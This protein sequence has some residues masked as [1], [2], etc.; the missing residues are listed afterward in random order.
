VKICLIGTFSGNLDEGYRNVAFNLSKHLS[1][2]HNI[3]N[4]DIT[5]IYSIHFWKQIREFKPHI[6]H[7]LTAPTFLSFAILKIARIRCDFNVKLV[8]S[9]LHPYSLKI[10]KNPLLKR[11]IKLMKPDLILTQ[12]QIIK[13]ILE[14]MGCK[15]G[16]LPNGVDTDRFVPASEE[17]KEK[18]REKYGVS[19]E[20][21]VILH[22]G[23]IRKMRGI[24]IFKKIQRESKENQVIIVGSSFFKTDEKLFQDLID[25]GCIVWKRYFKNIEEIYALADCYVFPVPIGES[26][27]MPLSVLEAMSCNLPVLS[28]KFEGLVDNFDEG[29]GLMFFNNETDLIAKL[30]EV[31]KGM[32]KPE[33]RKKVL[34]YSWNNIC[35]KLEILYNNLLSISK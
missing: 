1:K 35:I 3:V 23:H 4:M 25:S 30:K 11:M 7:Y 21:F 32:F 17:R 16:F 27:F 22:V 20:K 31:K 2:K 15:T 10:L 6:I 18:L 29:G 19:K 28:T 34:P 26:L 9:S 33:T 14:E 24:K 13:E 8:M 12:C 5:K